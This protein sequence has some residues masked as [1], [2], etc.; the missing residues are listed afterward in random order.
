M[1][2]RRLVLIE[3]MIGSGKST[4]AVRA[5]AM[6]TARGASVRAFNEFAEDH[7]IRTR[8]VDLLRGVIH[9][10]R[11]LKDVNGRLELGP[12]KTH[13]LKPGSPA[14]DSGDRS[15][16]NADQRGYLRAYDQPG[17]TNIGDGSDIGALEQDDTL[18][19]DGFDG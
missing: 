13:A 5:A 9:V 6:L 4:T 2:M 14:L 11:A 10:R 12:T 3:G 1:W 19:R 17:V 16:S 15:G 8:H 7:P 18:L